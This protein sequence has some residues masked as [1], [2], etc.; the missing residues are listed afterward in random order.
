MD[1]LPGIHLQVLMSNV[2][3]ERKLKYR[4]YKNKSRDGF[5]TIKYNL[6]DCACGGGARRWCSDRP[7][8]WKTGHG[9]IMEVHCTRH[10]YM[11]QSTREH[12][13]AVIRTH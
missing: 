3:T 1:T 5:Y 7:I 2:T 11:V 13:L 9:P 10:N 4:A 12:N 8:L 6:A